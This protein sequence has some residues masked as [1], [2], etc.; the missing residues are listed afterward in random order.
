MPTPVTIEFPKPADD[1]EFESLVRDLF[2]SHW[3]DDN[4]I[5]YGRS[6]Q[7]QNGVDV[8]G[9]PETS[10]L[11]YGIQCKIRRSGTLTKKELEKEITQA[12]N[13]LPKLDCYIIA[14]TLSRD[15]SLQNTALELNESF[16]NDWFEVQ[17]K[18]WEDI[19]L[20]LAENID[21]AKKYYKGF[22][23]S[24][25]WTSGRPENINGKNTI[26]ISKPLLTGCLID[27]SKSMVMDTIDSMKKP[28]QLDKLLRQII[29][30]IAAVSDSQ[31]FNSI[32][33]KIHFMLYGFGFGKFRKEIM[34]FIGEFG[35]VNTPIVSSDSIRNLFYEAS[36]QKSLPQ[37]PSLMMLKSNW[38]DYENSIKGQFLDMGLGES[39]LAEGLQHIKQGIKKQ[40]ERNFYKYPIMMLISNG[41]IERS[42]QEKVLQEAK[43]YNT[44]GIQ[45]ICIWIAESLSKSKK[46]LYGKDCKDWSPEGRLLF[47]ISSVINPEI[48]F[49]RK[50]LEIASDNGWLVEDKA[51]FFF[52]V[53]NSGVV[54]EIADL[55]FSPIRK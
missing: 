6:G 44:H 3:K 13:F 31:D 8:F 10:D 24:P 46:M 34:D 28:V 27:L 33:G 23:E 17:I 1:V 14:T 18:F 15:V 12:K 22:W 4:T 41:N 43:S 11:N 42:S 48:K 21:V 26:T 30:R 9:K 50:V 45:I 20:L 47:E 36:I 16:K 25:E 37:V 38:A 51:R 52:H 2:A 39:N 53:A 49:N 19:C 55:V 5:V 40:L 32:L 35:I 7:K 29:F 54:D